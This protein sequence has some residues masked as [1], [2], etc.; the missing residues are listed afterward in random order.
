[1]N[2]KSDAPPL[3]I[4]EEEEDDAYIVQPKRMADIVPEP[5][6]EEPGLMDSG[7]VLGSLDITGPSL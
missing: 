2:V 7:V 3:P 4:V 5:G 1:M 6:M